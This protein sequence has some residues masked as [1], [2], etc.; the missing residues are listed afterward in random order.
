MMIAKKML[1]CAYVLG[2]AS[3]SPQTRP[4]PAGAQSGIRPSGAC[5]PTQVVEKAGAAAAAASAAPSLP[6]LT[7][8]YS[9]DDGGLYYMQQSGN[10]LWWA[11]LSIDPKKPMETQWHRGLDF[12]HVFRGTIFCDGHIEGQWADVPRGSA[13]RSG[14]LNL[15]IDS[16]AGALVHLRQSSSSPGMTAKSWQKRAHGLNDIFIDGGG[17]GAGIASRFDRVLKNP[18]SQDSIPPRSSL[19]DNLKPYRDQTVVFGHIITVNAQPLGTFFG[20]DYQA[21]HVNFAT[22]D[23]GHKD[24]GLTSFCKDSG[25]GD[26]DFRL[27]AEKFE[28]AFATTGWGDNDHGPE[29]F[30]TKF[31]MVPKIPGLPGFK[32]SDTYLGLESIMYGRLG[33][34]DDGFT[35]ALLP[36]WADTAS[37]SVLIN[38]RPINGAVPLANANPNQPCT[39]LQPCPFVDSS[40]P[41][42]N[43][44]QLGKL[45]LSAKGEGT[46]VRITGTLVLDCGHGTLTDWSPCYDDPNDLPSVRGTLNQEI[47][48][49]YSIDVIN[50]PFRPE[51]ADIAAREN[52]TG[53]WAGTDGSTYY[54]RQI[55]NTIWWLG[56]MR[57]RQPMQGGTH[58]PMIGA[59]QLAPAFAAKDPAC[60]TAPPQCWAFATV[61]TGT[62]TGTADGGAVIQGTWAGVPQSVSAGSSGGRMTFIVDSRHK[63]IF[64]EIAGTIFPALSKLYEPEDTTPPKSTITQTP[65]KPSGVGRPRGA[66]GAVVVKSA[67]QVMI[68]ATDQGGSGV[69]NLWYRYYSGTTPKPAFTFVAGSTASFTINGSTGSSYAVDFY[70]TDNAGNDE[71]PQHEIVSFSTKLP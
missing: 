46:F 38:G 32:P 34:C 20:F 33:T 69:Q 52:L 26:F 49:I 10:T 45:L 1:C 42:N 18:A 23:F 61:F 17:T 31:D 2:M 16:P 64:P 7:G 62:L 57:D 58:F 65:A 30:K 66:A 59:E 47:H 3:A 21:P 19:L 29:I 25:D 13:L 36:G 54:I 41:L 4:V 14:T 51:D 27:K 39:F 40:Q 5:A 28:T 48:P 67:I 35:I 50:S 6:D 70:A 24:R 8:T 68:A 55:G 22:D 15:V 56:Q 12:S 11:G 43:G 71:A 63:A 37:N 53:A 9:A 60:G 44:I